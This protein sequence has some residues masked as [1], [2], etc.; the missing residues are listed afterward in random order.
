MSNIPWHLLPSYR[1]HSTFRMVKAQVS[2]PDQCPLTS[3][4][5]TGEND[6]WS[7]THYGLQQVSLIAPTPAAVESL[8]VSV[9]T[10]RTFTSKQ[11]WYSFI[12][13]KGMSGCVGW[14][15]SEITP[16]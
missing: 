6:A 14:N 8:I 4:Q 10:Q 13:P 2:I 7:S 5:A 15:T 12:N 16:C 1:C 9:A 3:W 11:S